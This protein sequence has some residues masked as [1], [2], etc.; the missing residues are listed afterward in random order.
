MEM[1]RHL[2]Q[3]GDA[4]VHLTLRIL[5]ASQE[6]DPILRFLAF[7]LDMMEDRGGESSLECN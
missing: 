5:Q 1:A 7:G 3:E 6:R 2:S 4:S